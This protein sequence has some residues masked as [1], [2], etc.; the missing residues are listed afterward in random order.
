MPV[1]KEPGRLTE[2]VLVVSG[3]DSPLGEGVVQAARAR[4]IRVLACGS[5]QS[6]LGSLAG[7]GVLPLT[8]RGAESSQVR[9]L[10]AVVE[11]RFPRLLGV[12]HVE[13]LERSPETPHQVGDRIASVRAIHAVLPSETVHVLAIEEAGRRGDPDRPLL[14]ASAAALAS[15]ARSMTPAMR[16]V[17]VP[18]GGEPMAW[19][20]LLVRALQPQDLRDRVVD[21]ARRLVGRRG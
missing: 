18:G 15:W 11:D 17:W 13:G 5:D 10:A 12:I 6:H 21:R 14:G 1:S 8:L 4:G 3:A 16:V 9:V 19:A 2:P 7:E 20:D